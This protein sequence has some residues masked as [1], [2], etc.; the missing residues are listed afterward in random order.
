[1][2]GTITSAKT[3]MKIDVLGR[4]VGSVLVIAGYFVVLNINVTAGVI[5]N[6][7]A[8]ALSLPFFIRTRTWD[9]VVMISFLAVVSISKL[10]QMG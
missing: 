5:T 9:V 7:A 8:D 4:I 6:L 10:T 2:V 3:Y 1:M